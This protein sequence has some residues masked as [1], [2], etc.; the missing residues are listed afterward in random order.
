MDAGTPVVDACTGTGRFLRKRILRK[1][2][3]E[4]ASSPRCFGVNES[5]A[6][7]A[8]KPYFAPTFGGS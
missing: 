2:T 6:E 7:R 4:R 1:R 3:A 8:L 5:L